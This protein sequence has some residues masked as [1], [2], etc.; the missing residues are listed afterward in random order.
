MFDAVC[1][2]NLHSDAEVAG[3]F[4]VDPRTVAR[5]RAEGKIGFIRVGQ[6]PRMTDDHILEFLKQRSVPCRGSEQTDPAKLATTGSAGDRTVPCGAGLGT[7][8]DLD[9]SVVHRSLQRI[10][11]KQN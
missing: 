4:D 1:L 5:W 3:Y 8:G 7:T 11:R 2:P 10:L 6:K 9:R